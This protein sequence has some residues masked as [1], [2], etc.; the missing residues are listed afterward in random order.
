MKARMSRSQRASQR[1]MPSVA[2]LRKRSTSSVGGRG[3]GRHDK[4]TSSACNNCKKR[5][6]RCDET[7]PDAGP[8][9]ACRTA[10]LECVWPVDTDGRKA[11]S[12][13][14]YNATRRER[15]SL[16]DALKVIRLTLQQHGIP[17]PTLASV[18]GH[19][20]GNITPWNLLAASPV[21][22]FS[23]S[24]PSPYIS[25]LSSVPMTRRGS[26]D[27][28]F[29]SGAED[30]PDMLSLNSFHFSSDSSFVSSS[31]GPL[32]V[33]P[34]PERERSGRLDLF[35]DI[36][37]TAC[38]CDWNRSLPVFDPALT[39]VEH[40]NLLHL[41][42][43]HSAPLGMG[44]IQVNFLSA[45]R[46]S[47]SGHGGAMPF[48][49]PALHN[50]MLAE[51][52]T[53]VESGL[54]PRFLG[55]RAMFLDA[56]IQNVS[57]GHPVAVV[58]T[59]VLLAHHYTSVRDGGNKATHWLEQAM[60]NAQAAGLCDPAQSSE[61]SWIY[62]AT[63]MQDILLA[64]TLGRNPLLPPC[65][66]HIPLV[67]PS[68][69]DKTALELLVSAHHLFK[70]MG[71]VLQALTHALSPAD[72]AGF[73][74]QFIEW[75][76]H[77]PEDLRLSTK[78]NGTSTNALVFHIVQR[79]FVIHLNKSFAE[80]N[81]DCRKHVLDA[82]SKVVRLVTM[83]KSAGDFAQSP[84]VVPQ[85]VYATGRAAV[86]LS[87]IPGLAKKQRSTAV[88]NAAFC[89]STL[90]ELATTWDCAA[91]YADTLQ[92]T[93]NEKNTQYQLHVSPIQ[94]PRL[95]YGYGGNFPYPEMMQSP[96]SAESFG[97]ASSSLRS[98]FVADQPSFWSAAASTLVTGGSGPPMEFI[99]Q[100]RPNIAP[101][102][103]F[104][105]EEYPFEAD[106][107]RRADVPMDAVNNSGHS[108][109]AL[110]NHFWNPY[111]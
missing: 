107:E 92:G 83:Y 24:G 33:I 106:I 109:T 96:G 98:P 13:E 16:R 62:H 30:S 23:S 6:T 80:D 44:V 8:C 31:A 4:H 93:L 49:S 77:L 36:G 37:G 22:S 110:D 71:N 10:A 38:G 87:A 53:F 104:Y 46:A 11:P 108:L 65:P 3:R 20:T 70:I 95:S 21:Q 17:D 66:V 94:L 75:A 88:E 79:W 61:A 18:Q 90:R 86:D 41:F 50:I 35:H 103:G 78:K 5:K 76:D 111:H 63:V 48:Y 27:A 7:R 105:L 9:N 43:A 101:A 68:T 34:S 56:A 91:G 73:H 60:Q 97:P 55:F 2:P 57:V 59:C 89:V 42:F 28:S 12:T 67:E 14:S 32:V 25:P 51:A 52:A 19:G 39:R 69:R 85:A 102:Q 54:K 26:G 84:S 47:L 45:M 99:Q 74:R 29:V 40:D 81:S 15:D 1:A 100:P 58:Q 82:T 72:V 64:M